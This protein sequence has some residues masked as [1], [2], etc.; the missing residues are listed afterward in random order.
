VIGIVH[1]DLILIGPSD[2]TVPPMLFENID[3]VNLGGIIVATIFFFTTIPLW[4]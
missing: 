1:P 3:D 4:T 2:P